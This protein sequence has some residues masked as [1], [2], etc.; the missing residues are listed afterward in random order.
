MHNLCSVAGGCV[1]HR[2]S[3]CMLVGTLVTTS[4]TVYTHG[5]PKSAGDF[6]SMIQDYKIAANVI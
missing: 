3:L 6:A 4:E 1:M 5:V 2:G